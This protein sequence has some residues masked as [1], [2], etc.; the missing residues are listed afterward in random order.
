MAVRH[1]AFFRE[2]STER[3]GTTEYQTLLAGA[4]VLRLLDKWRSRLEG[5]RDLKFHEFVA[6]KRAVEAIPDSPVRRIL[7]DLVHTISAFT[8]GSADARVPKL[9]AYAQL[10]E[11]DARYEAS[12]DVYLTA[13]ELTS[14][15]K[16]LVPLCYQRA[17][18][19]LRRLGVIDRAEALYHEGLTVAVENADQFWSLRL[20]VSLA[21][22]QHHKGDL[23]E[24]ERQLD[25]VITEA[26]AVGSPVAA[27]AR[28]E[29]GQVAYARDQD[30]LAAEYYY[31]AMKMYVDPQKKLRAMH[32][33]ASAL[34]DLGHLDCARTALSAI[35]NSPDSESETGHSAALNLMRI[36]VLVGEQ[37][38]FDRLRRELAD[39]RLTGH[40]R[41][42]YHVFVGQGY[43]EFGEPAKAREEF[44]QALI[45]AEQHRLYKVLI[46]AD[47]LLKATPE[48]RAPTWKDSLP[49]PGLLIILDEIR[50]RRAEFAEATE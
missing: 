27:E 44:A 46:E 13:I 22:L 47:A 14:G 30:A 9:I 19:C 38:K 28:H 5:D 45:V 37:V 49:H 43:L 35:Y 10:L 2:A 7:G 42:H 25:A 24:A 40:Q 12:A 32:D 39:Q 29:R 41:A 33:L 4:L 6:V 23:P 36:A 31:A 11:Y 17:G 50:H 34:V 1:L 16:E 8:D 26:D 48:V 21:M 18:A 3:E 20:R 15:D